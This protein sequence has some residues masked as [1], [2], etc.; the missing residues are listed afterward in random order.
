MAARRR[1]QHSS[2]QAVQKFNENFELLGD[3]PETGRKI[4]SIL[5]AN[6]VASEAQR[7]LGCVKS[8]VTYWKDKLVRAGALRLKC[9]GVIKYYELT[10]LG[11]KILAGS[12]GFPILFEDRP[13]KFR[14]LRREQVRVDWGKL[15]EPRNWRMLG[16]R[17]GAVRVRL[18]DRLGVN[19]DEANVI[20]HPGQIKG[21]SSSEVFEASVRVVE[22]TRALLET[23]FGMLLDDVGEVVGTPQYHVYRPECRDWIEA[24][25][26]SISGVGCLDASGTHDKQD[27]LN[28]VPHVEYRDGKLADVAAKFPSVRGY[29]PGLGRA[30]LEFPLVLQELLDENRAL[31]VKVESLTSQFEALVVSNRGLTQNVE[32]LVSLIKGENGVSGVVKDVGSDVKVGD[33]SYVR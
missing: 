4:L 12:E 23:K 16:V 20:I 27:P 29:G 25:C 7:V 2:K 9:D 3:L 31:S 19:H 32:R 10:E 15:G 17:L 21:F 18:H 13:V 5:G 8:N 26:V 33:D 6:G 14:V 28:G 22:R 11:S 24:G 30:G 1:V